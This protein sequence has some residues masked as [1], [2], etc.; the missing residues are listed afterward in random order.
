[1]PFALLPIL[2]GIGNALRIP[3]LAA[4]IAQIATTVF[5]WFFI[6]KARNVSIQLTIITMIIILTTAL[7]LAIHAIAAGL[8]FVVPPY[9]SQAMSMFIPNNAIPCVSAVYSA[10]LLRWVWSWKFYAITSVGGA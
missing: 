4:F 5:G 3:A 1:M 8:S 2:T 6:A 9:L 10:K 7:T